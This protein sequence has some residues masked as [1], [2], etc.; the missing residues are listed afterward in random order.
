MMAKARFGHEMLRHVTKE[1]VYVVVATIGSATRNKDI[2]EK[3]FEAGMTAARFD[4]SFGDLQYHSHS[5]ELVHSAA[6]KANRL[7]SILLDLGDKNCHIVQPYRVDENGW[8]QCTQRIRIERGQHVKLTARGELCVPEVRHGNCALSIDQSHQ[9]S[10][11]RMSLWKV[12]HDVIDGSG[13]FTVAMLAGCRG[14]GR[15]PCV[16]T[17]T[18]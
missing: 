14:R 7:C 4:L 1:A 11:T 9:A 13:D 6:T 15:A 18:S 17:A 10:L 16:S 8:H 5:L 3:L 12:L 2:L